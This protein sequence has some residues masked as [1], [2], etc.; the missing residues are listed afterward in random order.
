M[1]KR[2]WTLFLLVVTGAMLVLTTDT[3]SADFKKSEPLVIGG[4]ADSTISGLEIANPQGNG[5]TLLATIMR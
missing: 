5:I 1:K 3:L 4:K 2:R